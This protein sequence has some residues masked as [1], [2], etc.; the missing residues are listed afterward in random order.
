MATIRYH[1]RIARPADEV[2]ALVSDTGGIGKWFPGVESCSF[3]GEVRT[4]GTMGIE[5]LERVVTSDDDLRRFQY[6]IVGGAM[7]PE[8]HLA[9]IDVFE[10]GDGSFVV[11]SCEVK[12]DDAKALLDPVYAGGTE[13]LRAY[14]ES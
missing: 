6:S 3:D 7:V 11:Y 10:D 12:P 8:Y 13:A 9:T 2:W 4:V 1:T 14:F 5:V